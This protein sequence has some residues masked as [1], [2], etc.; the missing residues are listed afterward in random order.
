M[1]LSFDISMKPSVFHSLS[2]GAGVSATDRLWLNVERPRQNVPAV[3]PT[4]RQIA[5]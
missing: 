3:T 1:Q 2:H 4:H 5:Q